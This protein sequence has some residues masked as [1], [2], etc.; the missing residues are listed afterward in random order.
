MN[1]NQDFSSLTFSGLLQ[2][3]HESYARTHSLIADIFGLED[4]PSSEPQIGENC[5]SELHVAQP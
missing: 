1:T 2:E 3:V 5:P 4:V